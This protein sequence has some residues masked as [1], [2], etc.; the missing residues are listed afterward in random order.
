M[1]RGLLYAL[2]CYGAWGFLPIFWKAL[3]EVPAQEILAHRVV[4]SFAFLGLLMLYRQ[5][6]SWIGQLSRSNILTFAGIG[7]LLLL[8]WFTYIWAINA[9]FIVETSLGY[10]MNPLVNV[11]L[12]AL[13][14]GER[15]RSGQMIAVGIACAGV[16]YLTFSYGS[17]PWIG[18]TLAFTFGT[19]GLL[20]KQS[21]LSSIEGFT[22]EMS[23]L[24]PFALLYI[25]ILMMQNRAVTPTIGLSTWMLLLTSGIIT[26]VPLIA[27]AAAAHRLRLATLGLMQ[28]IAPTI[29]FLIGVYIY[30][31][32]FTQARA[33]GF[34]LIWIALAIYSGEALVR[35]G[36]QQRARR[37]EVVS[38]GPLA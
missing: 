14:L 28:Y 11:L 25:T 33:V 2:L 36:R 31:E 26:A 9:G 29:Q 37:R 19:Y 13:F 32:P 23:L 35:S 4:W 24:L 22:L 5:R 1:N 27:F 12:G 30:G 38:S 18:L 6:F 3:A 8:N 21:K 7:G 15:L 16:L 20:K 17:L 34:G 10:F